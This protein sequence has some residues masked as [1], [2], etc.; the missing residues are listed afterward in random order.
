MPKIEFGE[1]GYL[2]SAIAYTSLIFG[3]CLYVPFIRNYCAADNDIEKKKIVSTIFIGLVLWLLLV[4]ISFIALKPFFQDIFEKFFEIKIFGSI[5]YYLF[6]GAINSGIVLL[7]CYALLMAR[8]T[9]SEIVGY[10]LIKFFILTSINILCIYAN[11]WGKDTV[12]NRLLATVVAEFLITIAYFSY[13]FISFFSW[14]FDRG[15]FFANLRIAIPLIPAALISLFT[16]VIDRRLI[17]QYH[18]L[19]DLANY[20]LALQALAPM[21]MLMSAV[22]VAWAPHLFS[23]KKKKDALERSTRLIWISLGVMCLMALIISFAVYFAIH[24]KFISEDYDSVPMIILVA[25]VGAIA[26]ALVQ[27]NNNMFVQFDKTTMQFFLS[28]L[29]LSL[30]WTFNIYLVPIYSSYGAAMAAG[31]ANTLVLVIGLRLLHKDIIR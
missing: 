6:I 19:A 11:L 23:I 4:D 22:Q 12:V 10:L 18:G 25:S 7:Y 9:T 3:L 28:L 14:F 31:V 27:L 21:Q 16:S 2:T 17:A 13:K 8:K 24:E 26:N 29:L 30:N 1:F 20:N 5:K 15:V